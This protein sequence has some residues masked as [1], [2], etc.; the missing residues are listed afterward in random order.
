MKIEQ[1][2]NIIKEN[3]KQ[4]KSQSDELERKSKEKNELENEKKSKLD[5]IDKKAEEIKKCRDIINEKTKNYKIKKKTRNI[6]IVSALI[7]YIILLIFSEVLAVFGAALVCLIYYRKYK[8]YKK[9]IREDSDIKI[10]RDKWIKYEQDNVELNNDVSSLNVRIDNANRTC[11]ELENELKTINDKINNNK[12][13]IPFNKKFDIDNNN[14][15]DIAETTNVDKLLSLKQKEIRDIEKAENRDYIKDLSKI[16]I[17]LESFQNQLLSDY[18]EIQS[19]TDSSTNIDPLIQDFKIEFKLYKTLISSLVLMISNILNDNQLAY[20]KLRDLF[21]RLS[22]FES[23][24]EKKM[25]SKL[26]NINETQ[27]QL[28]NIT[29]SGKD[30][31]VEALLDVGLS[32]DDIKYK[33]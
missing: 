7:V 33:F 18:E 21:D 32:V 6:I 11:K 27:K 25:I 8:K 13:M 10:N 19:S 26:D 15:L 9:N 1:I 24:Y 14:R 16:C 5:T 29:E 28:V 30:E 31:I 23:N 4:V 20:Y 12:L 17:Y 22:I 2:E 3:K